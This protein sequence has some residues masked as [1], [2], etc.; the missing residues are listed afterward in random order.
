MNDINAF[1]E[2]YLAACH[3]ME[4]RDLDHY[5]RV[6][7]DRAVA[8]VCSASPGHED[9]F[10][11]F[12]KVALVNRMYRANLGG[13]SIN[14]GVEWNVATSFVAQSVDLVLAPLSALAGFDRESLPV[15]VRCHARLVA[16]AREP[17]GRNEESFASKYLSF[18]F[19]EV[20]PILDKYAEENAWRLTDGMEDPGGETRYE[21]YCY[22]LLHLLDV[23][24]GQGVTTPSIKLLDHVLY[25]TRTE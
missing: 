19:P 20:V 1:V 13:G 25:G 5:W 14:T 21:Q 16:I 6:P 7:F 11:V 24:R 12:P 23:L 22:R 3:L 18:H 8:A 9:V 15:I 10:D 2:R 17:A 4:A